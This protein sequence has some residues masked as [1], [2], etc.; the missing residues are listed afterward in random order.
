MLFEKLTHACYIQIALETILLP[1]LIMLWMLDII[2]LKNISFSLHESI[3]SWH[4]QSTFEML[5]I[6]KVLLLLGLVSRVLIT[7][8][9]FPVVF[10]VFGK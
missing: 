4:D 10:L 9:L 1:I 8:D 7:L 5:T 6:P 2:V 3:W